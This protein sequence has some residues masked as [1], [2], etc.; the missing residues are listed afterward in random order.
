MLGFKTD[1]ADLLSIVSA[2][3]QS[4][5]PALQSVPHKRCAKCL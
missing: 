5:A 1:R 2:D 4:P 3:L